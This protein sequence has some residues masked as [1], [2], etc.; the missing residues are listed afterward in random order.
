[1][2]GQAPVAVAGPATRSRTFG[3]VLLMLCQ[4]F[5]SLVFGGVG[6]FLPLIR[7]DVG[8][9]FGEAG[10][11]SAASSAVYALMQLPSGYLSDRIGPKRLFAVGLA[12]TNVLAIVFA[13][14]H[15]FVP[16]LL[17]Q[18][19]SGFFR[20][21]VFA[22]GLLLMTALFP[23]ERRATALGLYVAGGFSS[24]IFLN[25]LGPVLVHPLGWRW[26]FVIFSGGGL[27]MLALYWRLGSAGPGP[28]EPVPIRQALTLFR[29]RV[30]WVIGAI[31]YVRL[32]V[33][34]GITFWLPSYL[35]D[36]R[37]RSLALAGVAAAIA[38]AMTAPSNF[39]GGYVSD[40]LR[41]PLIVIGGSLA[42][43]A[44]TT[45][46]LAAV[47]QIVLVIV[48]VALNA[49]F[50]QL[51]FGPLFSIPIEMLGQRSA[52]LASGFGNFFANVGGFTFVYTLGKVKDVTGSFATG[53]YSLSG[54]ALLGLACA[55]ALSRMKPLDDF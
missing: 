44:V 42:M 32:A 8:L 49:L 48:I 24:N 17:S 5:Q 37:H 36:E 52:G 1:M 55:I 54:L 4:S 27:T 7:K 40:R 12:G 30:M 3:A 26:L 14:L 45:A 13:S 18:T 2:R 31:Q 21:L 6:L 33:V 28:K 47:H 15:G 51:Y 38:S 25:L 22:P 19:V 9:S 23:P 53:F 20:S 11:L 10:A 35:V 50:I 46:L 34:F 16:L 29:Y 43:I 41:S 39:L